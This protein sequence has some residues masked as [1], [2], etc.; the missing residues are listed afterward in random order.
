MNGDSCSDDT[1]L[2]CKKRVVCIEVLGFVLL[3]VVSPLLRAISN[4]SIL[5]NGSRCQKTIFEKNLSWVLLQQRYGNY[6]N[7]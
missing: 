6:G 1:E 3:G 4:D 5:G 2:P 7:Y